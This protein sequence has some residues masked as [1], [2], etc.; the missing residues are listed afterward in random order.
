MDTINDEEM[1]EASYYY[2]YAGSSN[3]TETNHA[4]LD[5]QVILELREEDEVTN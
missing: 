2:Y 5:Y 1:T 3:V 4:G